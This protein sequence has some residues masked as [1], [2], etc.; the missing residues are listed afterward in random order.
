MVLIEIVCKGEEISLVWAEGKWYG[1]AVDKR[2]KNSCQA[3]ER[4]NDDAKVSS[5][6]TCWIFHQQCFAHLLI[7]QQRFSL[8][9]YV[10]VCLVEDP[11]LSKERWRIVRCY[12][13][14]DLGLFKRWNNPIRYHCGIR[15]LRDRSLYRSHKSVFEKQDR[16]R[17]GKSRGVMVTVDLAEVM[18][19]APNH[20]SATSLRAVNLGLEESAPDFM[21]GFHLNI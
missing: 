11:V 20:P 19:I 9:T 8:S 17:Q 4:V 5:G 10:C 15:F 3:L 13:W 1:W 12:C 6:H 7:V 21:L 14:W 18:F 2:F 16:E